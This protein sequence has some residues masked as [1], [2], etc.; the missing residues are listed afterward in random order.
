MDPTIEFLW[1]RK[2]RPTQPAIGVQSWAIGLLESGV[3]SDAILR[4]AAEPELHWQLE[5]A[6]ITQALQDIGR[7]TLED[8]LTLLRAV[9]QA[10]VVDYHA[11]RIDGRT[12]IRRGCDLYYEGRE[13]EEFIP[14]IGLA[15][16]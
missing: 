10:S 7:S 15:E 11:S 14:W 12:L 1:D 6:L 5:E 13:E 16:E 9:E 2:R 8:H 4:L 3:E